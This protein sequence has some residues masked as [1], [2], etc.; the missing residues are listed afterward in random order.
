MN[1]VVKILGA[2]QAPARR[3][4]TADTKEMCSR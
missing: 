2:S 4:Y 3:P 1:K